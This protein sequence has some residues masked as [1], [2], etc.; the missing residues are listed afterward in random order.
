ME[1]KSLSVPELAIIGGTRAMV[2]AG[3]ALLLAEYL[4]RDQRR[5]VGWT[6]LGI[7]AISSIPIAF[8]L[9]GS[10]ATRDHRVEEFVD[11]AKGKA[12]TWSFRGRHMPQPG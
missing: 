10:S 1:R 5:A 8:Q 2:G 3:A 6:L 12:R 11:R 7:G 9:F 4:S